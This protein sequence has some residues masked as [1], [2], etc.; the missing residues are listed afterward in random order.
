MLII[1]HEMSGYGDDIG[2]F[3]D[4]FDIGMSCRSK[5]VFRY[6]DG[7]IW[8]GWS[9]SYLYARLSVIDIEGWM[10]LHRIRS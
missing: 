6:L 4:F 7:F 8:G 10:L 1:S 2:M 9:G 3:G 5:V